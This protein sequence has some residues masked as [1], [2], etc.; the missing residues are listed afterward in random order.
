MLINNQENIKNKIIKENLRVHQEESKIYDD[1]HI[2]I[3]NRYENRRT[4]K[5]IDYIKNLFEKNK[6]INL[7]DIGCGTGNI[8]LRFI[9]DNRFRITAVD[10]SK[11]ML[12]KFKKKVDAYKNITLICQ[13]AEE[14]LSKN[15][16]K[17]DVI[18]I[19]STLHHFY[20]PYSI[21]SKTLNIINKQG[22]IYLSHE[23]LC[24]KQQQKN[25]FS[26]VINFLDRVLSNFYYI[27]KLKKI[28]KINH[29]ISDYYSKEGI[30]VDKLKEMLKYNFN[31]LS[32]Q[33][34]SVNRMAITNLI[35]NKTVR[36]KKSFKLI[37]QK[38][39]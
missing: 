6:M 14:F 33:E 26:D 24:K 7:L 27:Y 8:S 21:F 10:L 17:Y 4:N 18:T 13:S 11:E 31:I 34:Y 35:D 9:A 28:P 37:A 22:I 29:T 38:R 39:N 5:D 30:D 19:Y 15:S 1:F 20:K 25:L 16:K 32:Y 23:P 36:T 2:E 3:F 12:E